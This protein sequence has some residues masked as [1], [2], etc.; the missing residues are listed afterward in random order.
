VKTTENF[1]A[2]TPEIKEKNTA[3]TR[4]QSNRGECKGQYGG[5]SIIATAEKYSP[6]R[7]RDRREHAEKEM[8]TAEA[9]NVTAIAEGRLPLRG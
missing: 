1:T 3:E 9:P 5:A 7:R 4:S 8:V 2:D 6:R